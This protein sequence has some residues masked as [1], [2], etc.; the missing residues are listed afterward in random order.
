M[1]KPHEI[2][3]YLLPVTVRLK[4]RVYTRNKPDALRNGGDTRADH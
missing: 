3:A 2:D 1:I 4:R